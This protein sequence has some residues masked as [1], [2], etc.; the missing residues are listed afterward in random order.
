MTT[1]RAEQGDTV[2]S[3]CWRAFGYTEQVVEQTLQLNHG[4]CE[5]GPVLP[6]G[7]PVTLPESP[8]TPE[9]PETVKLWD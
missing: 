4:L 3:I 9:Q 6:Q 2:D 7:Q 1:I 5:H 8:A